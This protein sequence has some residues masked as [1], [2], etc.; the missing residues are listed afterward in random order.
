M[1]PTPSLI[2]SIC[3]ECSVGCGVVARTRDDR[4]VELE[5]DMRHPA[6]RGDLCHRAVQPGESA[7]LDQR[8]LHPKIQGRK[9]GWPRAAA[10]IAKRL[11]DFVARHGPQSVAMRLSDRLLTEDYYIANKMMKGFIGS[12]DIALL[13][14]PHSPALQSPADALIM[15]LGEDVVPATADDIDRAKLVIIAGTDIRRD[16]PILWRR[17][18]AAQESQAATIVMI[19]GEK[20]EDSAASD[21]HLAIRHLAI[22]PGTESILFTGLLAF[23]RRAGIVDR[24]FLE[25]HVI[26]PRGFWDALEEG[27]D[28]WS[29]ARACDVAPADLQSFYD[30][31]AANPKTMTLFGDASLTGAVLNAHLATGRIGRPGAA[32]FPL[33]A[34]SNAMGAREVGISPATLAAHMD[35]TA[36]HVALAGRFWGGA[37]MAAQPVESAGHLIGPETRALW[38]VGDDVLQPQDADII[39]DAQAAGLFVIHSHSVAD[40]SPADVHLPAAGWGEQNGTSTGFDRMISRQRPFFPTAGEARPHWWIMTQVARD[41]GWRDAF[42]FAYPAEVYREHARLSAYGNAGARL[43]DIRRHAAI[44]NPAYDE[45][46]SW[47]WGG[48]PFMDG[49]FH[50]ADGRARLMPV[51]QAI[52]SGAGKTLVPGA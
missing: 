4:R 24:P 14:D 5:G 15:A 8:L 47:R 19:G 38:L 16:L 45:M 39:R 46:T 49:R 13:P 7:S 2:R 41:M 50:T 27:H 40:D 48:A 1:R 32:P 9:A 21:I 23:S 10:H 6:N 25:S 34:A 28:L 26:T 43:F 51:E 36:D 42:Y 33:A 37:N 22:R 12:A 17:I 11:A 35:F 29:T 18:V 31:F 52:S 20:P 3:A 44:S 30:L